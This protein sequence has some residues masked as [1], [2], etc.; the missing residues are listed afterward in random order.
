MTQ[1]MKKITVAAMLVALSYALM[2]VCRISLVPMASFLKYDPKDIVIALGGLIFGPMMTVAVSV[3]VSLLEMITVSESGLIGLIMN[4][5]SSC[6]FCTTT[7]WIYKKWHTVR[8]AVVSLLCGVGMTVCVMLLWNYL[9]TPIYMQVDRSIVA[10][11]LLPAILPFNVLKAGLNAGLTFLLYRPVVT[12][13]RKTRLIPP[14]RGG[15]KQNLLPLMLGV[16]LIVIT[17]VLVILVMNGV[18]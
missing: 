14:S 1:R 7:A 17:C 10:G 3:T 8:G 18:L 16:S 11:M 5:L 6:A 15:K 13:L 2:Y 9:V 12:A 4:V